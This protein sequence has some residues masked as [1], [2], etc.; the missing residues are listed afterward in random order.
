MVK[1]FY[2]QPEALGAIPSL[3]GSPGF[4]LLSES[5][6]AR[7]VHEVP[8]SRKVIERLAAAG[9]SFLN[10]K[11]CKWPHEIQ[12]YG[13]NPTKFRTKRLLQ[14][15]FGGRAERR[16]AQRP[17]RDTASSELLCQQVNT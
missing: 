11:T 3:R 1:R 13:F 9:K 17:Q 10:G 4:F 12:E 6:H 8:P 14:L 5:V 7:Y 15:R 2:R 16:S